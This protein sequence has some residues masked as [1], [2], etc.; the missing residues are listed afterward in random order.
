MGLSKSTLTIRSRRNQE[1]NK[2][3]KLNSGP[4]KVG[5]LSVRTVN[6]FQAKSSIGNVAYPDYAQK[7]RR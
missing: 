3:F 6:L 7:Q 5:T 4:Q 1:S 2:Q